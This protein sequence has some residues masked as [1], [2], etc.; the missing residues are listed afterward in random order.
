MSGTTPLSASCGAHALRLRVGGRVLVE[1]LTQVFAPGELW[2]VAG[3]NGA[4]KTSLLETLAGL[5]VP[6]AGRIDYD[7]RALPAWRPEQLARRRALMTQAHHDVFGASVLE[8]VLLGRFPHLTGWGWEDAADRAAALE[9]LQL[10]DLQTLAARDVR[11]LSGGERQRVA[12]AT[13][14]CQATPLLLLDEPLAHLDL[15]HQV[16]C[17]EVLSRWLSAAPRSAIFSCHDL[18]LARRFATHALLLDGRGGVLAGP[19]REVLAPGPVSQ[20]FGYPVV[21]IS[22]DGREAL[23]PAWPQA[24]SSDRRA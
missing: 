8:T 7:G 17:L 2:C 23:V 21:L 1:A 24:S 19:A 22:Q 14:L 18:D 9:A 13:A 4:G 11:T 10:L 6:A 16:A 5:R 15:H 12:L 3:P 20:A